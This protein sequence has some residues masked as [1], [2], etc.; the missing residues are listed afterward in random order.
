MSAVP[1][2]KLT[3]AEYLA[4]ERAANFK[5]EFFNGEM[6]AMAG[7]S[8]EHNRV[9]ENLVIEIGARLKGGR[10]QSYS[11]DQRVLIPQTELYAYPDI[12]IVCGEPEYATHDRDTLINPRVIIEVLS[13]STENYDRRLKFQHYEQIA[14]FQEYV[15]VAQDQPHVER[16]V[17]QPD[18]T[19]QFRAFANLADTFALATV[20]A[21]V[22][23]ADVYRG[24]TF[25]PPSPPP[26][27][28]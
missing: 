20:S 18:G 25:P 7:A 13:P 5:S 1:K 23:M 17:R 14:S 19:W 3:A 24:V 9:K 26:E 4:L 8:R 2:R 21:E 12:V 22:P 10:C 11:S 6:F 27:R 16:Y 15:L 28:S